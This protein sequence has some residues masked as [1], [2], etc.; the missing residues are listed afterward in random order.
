MF[1]MDCTSKMPRRV[2]PTEEDAARETWR[3]FVNVLTGPRKYSTRVGI[4]GKYA[5]LRDAYA[6]ID[7]ALEHS[8][9]HLSTDL[10][11]AWIDATGAGGVDVPPD[12]RLRASINDRANIGARVPRGANHKFV[13]RAEQHLQ[14]RRFDVFRAYYRYV[15]KGDFSLEYTVRLNN[16]GLFQLPATRVEAMYAPEMFGELPNPAIEVLAQ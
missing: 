16:P 3:G 9:A 4:L 13:H 1:A 6:S 15:P 8:A 5:A 2:K 14:E 12:V 10:D 11:V 7:K